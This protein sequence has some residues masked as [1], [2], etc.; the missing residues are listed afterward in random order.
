METKYILETN[1]ICKM[2]GN[3]YAVNKVNMHIEK[4]DIYGFV[5]ENGA[6][7][8]TIIRL[9]TG[10]AKPTSGTY[11]INGVPS[12]S[13]AIF[14]ER[15]KIAA[16][17]ESV[18]IIGDCKP[19][20]NL[21]YQR[22]ITNTNLSDEE[23]IELIKKV[24]LDYEA[25][26]DKKVGNFSLG[27]RQRLGIAVAMVSSPE[28]II[29]DEPMNGLDPQG[30]IEIRE[31]IHKLSKEGVTFLISSH[32]LSELEKVCNKVGFISK[33]ELLK[34][35]TMKEIHQN[36]RKRIDIYVKDIN[37]LKDLLVKELDIKDYKVKEE[38]LKIFDEVDVNKLMKILVDNKVQVD[39]LNVKQETVEDYY[40]N[41]LVRGE[42]N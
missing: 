31:I 41:L 12:N 1:D 30:F 5:G 14:K 38:K 2:Y 35:V 13:P 11:S 18:S 24:G 4:G 9:V 37:A 16:I 39:S 40:I 21:K 7:K 17:V 19:L 22:T 26:K 6:G 28:L 27:M 23:L 20:D 15:K 33:G 29:L 32:I 25:V 8:T 10:L 42:N 36:S 34:E 3:K